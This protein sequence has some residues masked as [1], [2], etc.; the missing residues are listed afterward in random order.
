[1]TRFNKPFLIA[2]D[3]DGC[4]FDGLTVKQRQAFIPEAIRVFA[5]ADVA[6]VYVRCA[7]E[8]N[9]FSHLRGCN[10]FEALC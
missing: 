1:M 4:A 9:L 6:E 7:E 2:I 8:V 5:L 10:R 3:S